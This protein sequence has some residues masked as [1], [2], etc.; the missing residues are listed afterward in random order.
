MK[1]II[2]RDQKAQT[3]I[4]G[5]H[6]GMTFL[7]SCRVVLSPEEQALIAKYKAEN[8]P[9]TFGMNDGQKVPRDTV[10]SLTRGVTQE[11]KD[12][13]VLLENEEVI[14]NGCLGFKRLLEVMA[15]F[16]GEEVIEIT[17]GS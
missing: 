15:T 3:G 2:K 16:G 7:L 5:G 9:I 1:L 17:A 6:K 4:L 14:K 13:T 8:Y 10:S 11:L 12:I